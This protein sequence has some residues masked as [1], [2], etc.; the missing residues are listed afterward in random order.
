[1]NRQGFGGRGVLRLVYC[2]DVISARE[3]QLPDKLRRLDIA[4]VVTNPDGEVW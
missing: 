2:S 4:V 1:M 3:P